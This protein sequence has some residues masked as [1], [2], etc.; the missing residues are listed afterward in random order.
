MG[1]IQYGGYTIWGYTIWA[2]KYG[3]YT[4]PYSGKFSKGGIFGN[5]GKKPRFPKIYFLIFFVHIFRD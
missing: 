4:I 5:F 1:V 2:I 3:G